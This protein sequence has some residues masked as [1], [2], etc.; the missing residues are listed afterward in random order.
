MTHYREYPSEKIWTVDE[1]R[2]RYQ[3]LAVKCANDV[4]ADR[5]P[6]EQNYYDELEDLFLELAHRE[7]DDEVLEE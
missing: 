5:N 6:G 2:E 1:L 4:V 7:R 3:E